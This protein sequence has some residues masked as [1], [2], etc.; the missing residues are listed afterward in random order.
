MLAHVVRADEL[1]VLTP[2]LQPG[3]GVIDVGANV[4]R[5]TTKYADA[6]GPTGAVLAI[7][8]DP[9]VAQRL[10]DT[11]AARPWVEVL[12]L[13]V[14]DEPGVRV[15]YR[16]QDPTRSSLWPENR[17]ADAGSLK[18]FVARLDGLAEIVPN[19]RGVKIDAQG[20]EAHIFD[21]AA[22]TLRNPRVVWQIE[23]WPTGL[24]T[25][26]RD[27][28]T[29]LDRLEAAGLRSP[30]RTWEAIRKD[31]GRYSEGHASFDVLLQH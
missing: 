12:S 23:I 7:E 1:A 3:D 14:G 11:V 29:L 10:R 9:E 4:G 18:T 24:K 8:P 13:A 6:V 17:I 15:L 21:G 27:A 5:F 20:A 31:V 2:Y 26:G 25:A 28:M 19:L 30:S 22:E 16:D